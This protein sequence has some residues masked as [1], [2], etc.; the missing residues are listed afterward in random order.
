MVAILVIR[1]LE[2]Y[3]KKPSRFL[4][5]IGRNA[6]FYFFAQ[7][8]SVTVV[9]LWIS[10]TVSNWFLNYLIAMT[11]NMA[12]AIALAEALSWLYKSLVNLIGRIKK[13][14]HEA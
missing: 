11:A 10:H 13:V 1:F 9:Y 7:A 3:V 4:A 8:V 2:P 14:H 12:I 5:H 6:I